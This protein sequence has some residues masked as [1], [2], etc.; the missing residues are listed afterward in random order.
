MAIKDT[1][2]SGVQKDIE[3]LRNGVRRAHE[4]GQIA[5]EMLVQ[6]SEKIDVLVREIA[7]LKMEM[8]KVKTKHA[9]GGF[10]RY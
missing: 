9:D 6:M 8:E 10:G 1:D 5:N 7:N 3:G 4:S 2:L